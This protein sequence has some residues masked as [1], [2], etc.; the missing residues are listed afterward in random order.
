MMA[1]QSKYGALALAPWEAVVFLPRPVSQRIASIHQ[2]QVPPNPSFQGT[3]GK[4]RL[5]VPSGLRPP[6]APELKR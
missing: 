5:P 6:A 3:A 2:G 1:I 4:L